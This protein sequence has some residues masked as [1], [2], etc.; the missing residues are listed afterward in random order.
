MKSTLKRAGEGGRCGFEAALVLGLALVGLLHGA[1]EAADASV[2]RPPRIAPDYAGIVIPTN[3]A[4]LNFVI[5]EP[6][7]RYRARWSAAGG[8][9][10]AVE[11]K[12]ASIRF[13]AG[14]WRRFLGVAAGREVRVEV[15]VKEANGG[16]QRFEPITNTVAPEGIDS[17]LVYRRLR[18]LYNAYQTLGIYQRDLEGSRERPVLEGAQFGNGCLNCHTFLGHRPDRMALNIRLSGSPNPT[19]LVATNEVTQLLKTCG[20]LSWHPSGRLLVFSANRLS[21]FFHTVGETRDVFDADSDL[22]LYRVDSNTVVAPPAIARPDRLETWPSWGP[23]GRQLYF[24]SAP[25]LVPMKQRRYREVRYDLVRV[26][27]DVDRDRWGE[28]ETVVSAEQMQLSAAQPRVSPDGRY[29]VYG[30]AAYGNFPIYQTNADLYVQDLRSGAHR[31]LEI[32]SDA[33]DTWHCWSSNSRWL[34]FSSK[35]Q[36][37]VFARP[38]FTRVDEEGRFSKPFVLPQADPAFYDACLQT[39]NVPELVSGPVTVSPAALAR[40]VLK[41]GR[42]LKPVPVLHPERPAGA[43]IQETTDAHQEPSGPTED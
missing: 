21:L 36:D 39:F 38:Y 40:G 11:G 9:E 26:S 32:N 28:A 8:S 7:V 27:Y 10:V 30:L 3:I 22:G 35:R 15:A 1:G 14:S 16:W 29:L 19:L 34:V 18:P 6:G 5:R 37:G 24:C 42:V 20:Y 13:P 23:D 41:P 2:G 25:K 12:S 4:P 33:A 43:G 31:R 17:T